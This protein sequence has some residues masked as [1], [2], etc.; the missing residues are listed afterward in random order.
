MV[1]VEGGGPR[2]RHCR[3]VGFEKD[4]EK[5]NAAVVLGW[6]VLRFTTRQVKSAL[7]INTAAKFFPDLT[8]AVSVD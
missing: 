3:V 6:R 8:G 2:G 7:A 1:E 5:Y 4:C